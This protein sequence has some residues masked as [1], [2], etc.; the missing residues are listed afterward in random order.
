MKKFNLNVNVGGIPVP[1]F[2]GPFSEFVEIERLLHAPLPQGYIDFIMSSDGGHP[3][4]GCFLIQGGDDDNWVEVD[5]FYSFGYKDLP[6]VK[7]A[8]S[9]YGP[10]IGPEALPIGM[11]GGGNQFYLLMSV[12]PA[13]V[14]LYLHDEGPVSVKLADSFEEFIAGLS[15]DPDN[16]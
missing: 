9:V 7:W 16:I 6:R 11:D 10:I 5:Y 4:I 1:G 8:L 14:W 13:S 2:A 3:E 15:V 12:R